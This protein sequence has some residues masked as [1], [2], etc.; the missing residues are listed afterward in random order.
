MRLSA[1]R[2]D[3]IYHYT[4]QICMTGLASGYP[5]M[6]IMVAGMEAFSSMSPLSVMEN[7]FMCPIMIVRRQPYGESCFGHYDPC[8][9]PSS[10]IYAGPPPH[11]HHKN[12]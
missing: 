3:C 9:E 11:N 7:Y 4:S 1:Y 2:I 12:Q 8:N 5:Y 10:V 6:R